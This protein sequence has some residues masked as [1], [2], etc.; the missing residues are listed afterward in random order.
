MV[1][2]YPKAPNEALRENYDI[3]SEFNLANIEAVC[4]DKEDTSYYLVCN[5]V[6]E[7]LGFYVLKIDEENP[8]PK[9]DN[10]LIKWSNKLN[11]G[12]TSLNILRS[13]VKD[14]NGNEVE[15]KELII[16]YK[17]IFVNVYDVIVMDISIESDDPHLLFRHESYQLW[18]SEC[19]GF[20]IT[21]TKDFVSLNIKGMQVLSLGSGK[22]KTPVKDAEGGDWMLHSLEGASFLKVDPGNYIYFQ[23]A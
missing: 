8:L 6:E 4:Y 3:D 23:C 2:V 19:S 7:K 21:N 17:K 16:G 11:F 14:A 5:M 10:F 22:D 13:R 18:E 20:L 1:Y 12:N 9:D 15:H